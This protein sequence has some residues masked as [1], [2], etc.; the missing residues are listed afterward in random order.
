MY[1]DIYRTQTHIIPGHNPPAFLGLFHHTYSATLN[2]AR[3][4]LGVTS[5]SPVL[6]QPA[7]LSLSQA[8]PHHSLGIASVRCYSLTRK[9]NKDAYSALEKM[10]V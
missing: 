4:H 2:K 5:Q 3:A 1:T 7:Q 10:T 9:Q 8:M 6:F